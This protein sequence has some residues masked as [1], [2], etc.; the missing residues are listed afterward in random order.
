MR[1]PRIVPADLPP[2]RRDPSHTRREAWEAARPAAAAL[3]PKRTRKLCSIPLCA[4]VVLVWHVQ[5]A[6]ATVDRRRGGRIFPLAGLGAGVL[7]RAAAAGV[8]A[9]GGCARTRMAAA[10][11]CMRTPAAEAARGLEVAPPGTWRLGIAS[12]V[13][14]ASA[15]AATVLGK[16]RK[17]MYGRPSEILSELCSFCTI[18]TCCGGGLGLARR[19]FRVAAAVC[20]L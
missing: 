4:H 7:Q 15:D 13:H 17:L 2:L 14:G 8:R 1:G 11:V 5:Q 20:T 9:R 6:V 3:R 18:C 12:G 10:A 16:R 19:V